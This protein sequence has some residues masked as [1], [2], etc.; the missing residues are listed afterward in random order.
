MSS[1][2][3]LIRNGFV[4]SMDPEVGHVSNG[5][6]LVED[7]KIAEIGRGLDVSEA[8]QID[9]TG[10]IV[11]PGF[12]DTHRHTWQTPVR[13]VLPS[14]TLDHYFAVMLGSVGGHYRPEDVYIGDYAGALEALN[15]G[16]TT[17]LDWSHI[18]NTPDHSDAAI[19]GLKD[20]GIRAVYAHGMPTGGEWWM[21]SELNHPEDI[22]R[23]RETYFSSDDGLLTLAM[24][25]RQ[26]GNVNADV[27][28]HDWALARELGILISVHVGM[29]LHNLHYTPVKDMHDLGLMGPDVCYIHMTDLTD[30]ELDW[31]AET[32]GK[33]SIAPYVEML[34]GH[35]PPPTGKMLARG[36]RPSLS[37]DV[38]SSVPGEMFTQMRTALAYDRILEFTDTP[39]I[40]FAP[41]L[42]HKD[43][44]EFA[45]IDG[46][47]SIGL[48]DRVGSLTP[49][50]QADIVLLKVNAINTAPM[51]DPIG[52]V[53]VFADTSNVDSVFVAGRAVKRNGELVGADLD[54][55]FAK[56]DESRNHILS[57]GELLPEWAAA[58]A[59]AV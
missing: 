40:A 59:A 39:D 24:A 38:V 55:V 44:L 18:S 51:V 9:A 32:G 22:R 25:A 16:V 43:V 5:D 26:P 56:L 46:A 1:E 41:T 53:V 48:E 49:G 58:P 35:G 31:I 8:E 42:M 15:G 36:V 20:A 17:L 6:V 4:V 34:M 21:L 45:T 3:L 14:C 11:M 12:V 37:V 50:K 27:A 57:E 33:A 10:M 54:N 30:E 52:T 47:R 7:G 2:R 28:K 13:G 29:R 23:I 19:Q